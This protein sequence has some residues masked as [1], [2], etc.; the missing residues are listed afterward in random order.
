MNFQEPI[1][2]PYKFLHLPASE[3]PLKLSHFEEMNA[4][5]HITSQM[6]SSKVVSLSDLTRITLR[7]M[8]VPK[9]HFGRFLL[10]CTIQHPIRIVGITTTIQDTN[11]D[12][13]DITFYNFFSSFREDPNAIFPKGTILLIKEPFL[14]F[15]SQ[16]QIPLI[17]VDSPSDVIFVDEFDQNILKDNIWGKPISFSFEEL[18]NEGER[19]LRAKEYNGALQSFERALW[20]SPKDSSVLL[21]KSEALLALGRFSEA[22]ESAN[23]DFGSEEIEK[24]KFVMG[25]AAFGKREWK[26]ALELFE[27]ISEADAAL[28]KSRFNES[29]TGKFDL[30]SITKTAFKAWLENR[31]CLFDVA[32]FAMNVE[33]RDIRGKDKGLV[34]KRDLSKGSLILAS[35]AFAVSHFEE[36]QIEMFAFD[37]TQSKIMRKTNFML[38][39]KVAQ[40]LKRNPNRSDEVFSLFAGTS[41]RNNVPTGIIDIETIS[42]ICDLN[43]FLLEN[44][45]L[46]NIGVSDFSIADHSPC[47]LFLLPAFINHACC[48]NAIRFIWGDLMMVYAAQDIRKGEEILFPYVCAMAEF[49]ERS[50]YLRAHY[51]FVCACS[52]CES[53]RNDPKEEHR[54][55]ETETFPKIEKLVE[56]GE[57]LA[58]EPKLRCLI[59]N[60]EH[61]YKGTEPLLRVHLKGKY[62]AMGQIL[63]ENGKFEE[64]NEFVWKEIQFGSGPS[65]VYNIRY[66]ILFASNCAAMSDPDATLKALREAFAIFKHFAEDNP[67]MFKLLY[68]DELEEGHL[69]EIVDEVIFL[70]A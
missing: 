36:T 40:T 66:L 32:D 33:V 69:E 31:P 21:R 14:K 39:A 5:T 6:H 46:P 62:A 41:E 59:E 58:A 25:K 37:V 52:L 20:L 24:R 63:R 64:S 53:Q 3:I 12:V 23:I 15:G 57:F 43:H 7:E 16:S 65:I 27:G 54:L 4:Q 38:V 22:F 48:S 35:K 70:P 9:I 49:K 68:Q 67:K 30:K 47:G 10:C 28:S 1:P 11:G 51:N 56:S 44:P 2:R 45:F 50:E 26:L 60:L 17:R 29:F 42:R 19:F 8:S 61:L 18:K 34:T 55:R 13:E